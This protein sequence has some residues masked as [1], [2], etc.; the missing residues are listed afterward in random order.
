MKS[1]TIIFLT[2]TCCLFSCKE[3]KQQEIKEEK[4]GFAMYPGFVDIIMPE[5]G[6]G[7]TGADG[8]ISIDLKDGRSLFMWGDCF[9]GD[10]IDNKRPEKTSPLVMG[11][12][13][14]VLK[15]D[16]IQTYFKGT[17]EKPQSWLQPEAKKDTV[18]WYWPGHGFV[19]D[20][21]LHLFMSE[22]Y[23]SK[24][25]DMFG[26][27]YITC[28]YFRLNAETFEVIDKQNFPAAN[29]NGVHYGHA[30][31]DDGKY[32]YNYGTLADSTGF[33]TVH[34]ARAQIENNTLQNWEY[35][36]G[37]GWSLNAKESQ[38]LEGIKTSVSEQFN[39][40][41]L[42]GKYVLVTQT[43]DRENHVFSAISDTPEGP[44]YN[45]KKI[46]S[47]TEPLEE[48]KMITYNT[49]VHPQ[50]QDKGRIL[51]CYN[52]NCLEFFDLYKDATLYKPRFFW[53][54]IDPILNK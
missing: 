10:V 29:I 46:F 1:K 52:V 25:N 11:N 53:M 5:K 14:T 6:G 36:T 47:V 13:F 54:P 45:E 44:F 48:K 7:V 17:R 38:P 30:V 23:K 37:N 51:M 19:R 43:R 26:F 41:K 28:D 31:I 40:F 24:E 12:V 4:A 3:N 20:G 27:T 35:Y 49:M 9:I 18:C 42:N 2:I 32:I 21:I 16:S 33:A 39:M 8:S 34:V 22:F 50:F 15:G